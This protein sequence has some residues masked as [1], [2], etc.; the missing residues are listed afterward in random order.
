MTNV[1]EKTVSYLSIETPCGLD[2]TSTLP[3]PT[4]FKQACAAANE[5]CKIDRDKTCTSTLSLENRV[6]PD[7]ASH[8]GAGWQGRMVIKHSYGK[9]CTGTCAQ[10]VHTALTYFHSKET[11]ILSKMTNIL[12][13]ETYIDAGWQGRTGIKHFY[14]TNCKGTCAQLFH[15]KFT[16]FPPKRRMFTQ[17]RRQFTQKR[18]KFTP[19]R[20][21]FRKYCG[22][23]E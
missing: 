17:K 9:N 14:G 15:T 16:Y 2:T 23:R 13:K 11:Y 7:F 20:R 18:R 8:N 22:R 6:R 4:P 1:I 5:A 21:I 3:A 19:T 12:S 10:V